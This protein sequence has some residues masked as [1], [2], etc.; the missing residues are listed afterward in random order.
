MAVPVSGVPEPLLLWH[1]S[2]KFDHG[3]TSWLYCL[4]DCCSVACGSA[5]KVAIVCGL[6]SVGVVVLLSA[7]PSCYFC[8]H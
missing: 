5:A 7:G 6:W 4:F 1:P 2:I 3:S 8:I